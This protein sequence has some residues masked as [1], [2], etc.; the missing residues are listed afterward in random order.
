M[1]TGKSAY[2]SMWVQYGQQGR[3][4]RGCLYR[5]LSENKPVTLCKIRLGPW[6]RTSVSAQLALEQTHISSKKCS[7]ILA[8]GYTTYLG[9]QRER[10]L[11]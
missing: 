1:P 11:Y 5:D 3:D 2:R 7:V 4:N 9:E 8:G 6:D 10:V